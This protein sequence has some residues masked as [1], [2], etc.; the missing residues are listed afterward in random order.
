MIVVINGPHH[1]DLFGGVSRIRIPVELEQPP[2]AWSVRV[3][4]GFAQTSYRRVI[5][6]DV[7]QAAAIVEASLRGEHP[8][9]TVIDVFP[10][11]P[12]ITL[13][14]QRIYATRVYEET[15]Q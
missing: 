13:R 14:E 4:Y 15:I 9:A 2:A 10:A 12:G 1:P 7:D 3:T 5:A 6:T 11:D 8:A